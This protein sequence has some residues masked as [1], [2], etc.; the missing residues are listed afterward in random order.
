M[1]FFQK[2]FFS[3]FWEA[4]LRP[5]IYFW[6]SSGFSFTV[7]IPKKKLSKQNDFLRP[8]KN[9]FYFFLFFFIFIFFYFLKNRLQTV[10]NAR[11]HSS[12]R[13]EIN[14]GSSCRGR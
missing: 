9:N 11:N 2:F 1:F 7:A 6:V 13:S 12:K 4:R 14:F 8:K 5:K 10:F 3:F